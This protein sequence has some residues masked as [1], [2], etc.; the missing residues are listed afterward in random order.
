MYTQS[1]DYVFMP[2]F[3]LFTFKSLLRRTVWFDGVRDE[4]LRSKGDREPDVL[5]VNTT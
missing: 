3:I 5:I 1:I 2:L 4:Q